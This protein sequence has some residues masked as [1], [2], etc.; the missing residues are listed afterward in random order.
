MVI[1]IYLLA[2]R[3]LITFNNLSEILT[4]LIILRAINDRVIGKECIYTFSRN[5]PFGFLFKKSVFVGVQLA[6]FI[7]Y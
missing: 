6:R 4:Q 3:A 7:S 2:L 1:F 5:N